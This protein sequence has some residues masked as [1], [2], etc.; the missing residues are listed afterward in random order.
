ML[1]DAAAVRS[2]DVVLEVGTGT[3]SLT[4]LLARQAAAVV[5]VEVDPHMFQLASEELHR[6]DNVV[7]LQVDALRNKNQ[8]HA[9]LLDAVRRN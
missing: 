8:L 2:D 9:E 3:G 7:M 5:T 1:L 4:A 6:L